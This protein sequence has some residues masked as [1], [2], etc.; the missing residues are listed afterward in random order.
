MKQKRITIYQR[1]LPH[2]RV[3]FF[4]RLYEIL[5]EHD[6][7]LQVV[8]GKEKSGT[9]PKTVQIDAPWATYKK[10]NY[11]DF[12]GAELIFQR[13]GWRD[14]TL[15]NVVIVEQANRLLINY[16]LYFLRAIGVIKLGFWGHGKNFQSIKHSG[17]KEKLK[18]FYSVYTDWWFCY[19]N[20]G[21]RII[22]QLDFPTDQISVVRNSVDLGELIEEQRRLDNRE[23]EKL[24]ECLGITGGNIAVYCGGMYAEKKIKF[25]L[26]ACKQ[27]KAIVPDYHV[28]FIG[29]GPDEHLV[30]TFCEHNTWAHYVG[31]I[32]GI[33]RVKYFSIGK[34]LLMPGA[35]G[36][37][38]LDSFA[39]NL[40]MITTN[41][42]THGPE[43]D[44]LDSEVNGLMVE[45]N[46][47]VYAQSVS[48]LLMDDEKR[49]VL[50]NGC[51]KSKNLYSIENMAQNFSNGV[52]KLLGK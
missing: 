48:E 39:L 40:P 17:F 6:I 9:V 33:E 42:L 50:V 27:L 24:K 5:L 26:D 19:T 21:K 20:S 44:Y 16:L 38:I 34:L 46:V 51:N 3:P 7:Q 15:G 43:I 18:R 47:Q 12:F 29:S 23:L 22:S 37:A 32:S 10:V 2:Y 41:I 4:E 36:L 28:I 25:L 14:L 1:V 49:K 11:L 13:A 31:S 45:H 35:V 52:L 30:T 8:F